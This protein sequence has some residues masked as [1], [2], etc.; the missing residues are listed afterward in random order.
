M[1][2]DRDVADGR[3]EPGHPGVA[4][5]G[6]CARGLTRLIDD[7]GHE[8]GDRRV[9]GHARRV[10]ERADVEVRIGPVAAQRRRATLPPRHDRR[11]CRGDNQDGRGE[12]AASTRRCGPEMGRAFDAGSSCGVSPEMD[13]RQCASIDCDGNLPRRSRPDPRHTLATSAGGQ[14]QRACHTRT[15]RSAVKGGKNHVGSLPTGANRTNNPS[16]ESSGRTLTIWSQSAE[17][18][19]QSGRSSAHRPTVA[20]DA[21]G[22]GRSASV[23]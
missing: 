13:E 6:E 1:L 2:V 11:K 22:F 9:V 17:V 15:V 23:V 10:F 21:A 7:V 12:P 4:R 19:G 5:H 18:S 16:S 8:I 14:L 20:A 3:H